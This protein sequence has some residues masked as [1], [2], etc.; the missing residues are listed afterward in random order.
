[1]NAVK[2]RLCCSVRHI[3]FLTA[4]HDEKWTDKRPLVNAILPVPMVGRR[5]GSEECAG[6]GTACRDPAALV[7]DCHLARTRLG[8]VPRRS[9]L[10]TLIEDALR[11][12][13]AAPPPGSPSQA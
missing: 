3:A 5:H 4:A 12:R 13:R 6:H 9:D 8:F 1:M 7:A 2:K 10:L 11:S